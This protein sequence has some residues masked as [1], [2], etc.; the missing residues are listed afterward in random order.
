MKLIFKIGL[1]MLVLA[2]CKKEITKKTVYDDTVFLLNDVVVYQS[3]SQKNKQKSSTQFISI[4][5]A[6]LF[7]SAISQEVLYDLSQLS[8][9]CGDKQLL[10]NMLVDNY[11]N[12]ATANIPA[13]AAMRANVEQF[14]KDT[15]IR[16]YLRNPTE[17]E[18]FFLKN[19]I[20][21]DVNLSP[22]LIYQAF[23]SSNEYL[24]Y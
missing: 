24:F 5:Y 21:G 10:N 19:A 17:Y 18:K 9:S 8:Q 13:D 6:D 4:L 16:F 7:G 23:A 11:I 1:V 15:Y 22:R 14:I 20:L 12:G 2:G 3:A